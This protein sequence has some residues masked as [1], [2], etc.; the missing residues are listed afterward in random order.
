[1]R[2]GRAATAEWVTAPGQPDRLESNRASTTRT[3][4][5]HFHQ[6]DDTMVLPSG[7]RSLSRRES[8]FHHLAQLALLGH[9]ELRACIS[10]EQFATVFLMCDASWNSRAALRQK[11]RN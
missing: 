6:A 11:V 9:V 5:G 7:W 4:E 1:M 10:N 8:A 3:P 2:R